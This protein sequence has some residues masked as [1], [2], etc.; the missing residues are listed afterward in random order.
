MRME[1]DKQKVHYIYELRVI[2]ERESER[3]RHL[4]QLTLSVAKEFEFKNMNNQVF[5]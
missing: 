4:S 3:D 2:E 1:K 5:F